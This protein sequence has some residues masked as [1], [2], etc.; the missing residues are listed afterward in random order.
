MKRILTYSITQNDL[1]TP[2]S[3]QDYL[4]NLGYPHTVFVYLRKNTGSVLLNGTCTLLKTPLKEGDL[5]TI[6]LEER[7]SSKNIIPAD[8][9]LSICYEDKDILVLNKPAHMPIHPSMGH[10]EST[11]ANAVT[12]YFDSCG[13]PCPFR[14]INRLDRD[15][16]GL[17]IV[18]K[19]MLSA[20]ILNNAMTRRE[21][22]REYLAIVEGSTD[23]AGTIDAPI[24]RKDGSTI[25]REVNFL[26]GETAVTHYRKLAERNG[27]SLLSLHL[28]TGKTHQIRVHLSYIGHPLIGDFLYHPDNN[29][30]KRQ[31][32]HAHR[33]IFSHPITGTTMDLS[34][35]LPEDMAA[36]FPDFCAS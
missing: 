20:A 28:D 26:R 19:H 21:I 22:S 2:V 11:L 14:C 12:G 35:T 24:A 5:L 31:A 23:D 18:A 13:T 32:L 30:I 6:T 27:L 9:P 10:H 29:L 1:H 34:A 36:F 17:T 3:I 33:L 8:I 16:T 4:K 15:T 25:E 7:D